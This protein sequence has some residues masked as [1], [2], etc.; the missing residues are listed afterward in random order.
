MA[1]NT[2][3][4]L[5]TVTTCGESHGEALGAIIDGVPPLIPISEELIQKDLDRRRPGSTR[6]GTPRNEP[7]KVKIISGIFEGR[8][9]G[10]PM[11]L[12]I[13]N[14]S[15]RSKDYDDIKDS[16]RPGHA[17]LTYDL[18][19]GIR[20]YRGGGRSSAR[21]TAM[22]VAAGAVAKACLEELFK[23]TISGCVTAIGP[24]STELYDPQAAMG[25]PFNF[26]DPSKETE[27]V[28][29][30]H[31]LRS[32]HDSCG[33]VVEVRAHNV[34]AGIGS[35][36]FS[37][38]DAQIA[39]ALMSINAVKGVEIGDGF[40]L[41][42][43]RGTLARDE[44]TSAG[45]TSNHMGGI[46]GGISSGQEIRAR[47]ALKPTSSILTP[48]KSINK[49]GSDINVVTRGRHDPCVGLR[50]VPIAE[51]ML[52]I[53]LLDAALQDQ[54]QCFKVARKKLFATSP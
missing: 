43:M 3:G 31:K 48:G 32:D 27:L 11:G 50:A 44:I 41:A 6:F 21:E 45:F 24:I 51:A 37:R 47:I 14:T 17:D 49:F 26:A 38:L 13:E 30:F 2:I 54:G 35:P 40:A 1:G 20:D 36:V 34:P 5:F 10:T 39:G 22:R 42:A 12:I 18:K 25:N 53:V 9:T 4:T 8:T 52:A 19:Y 33:A 23:I 46:L 7:D 16:Y 28:E 29:Y 15:Q